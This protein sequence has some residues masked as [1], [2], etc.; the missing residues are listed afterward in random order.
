MSVHYYFTVFPMEAMIASE[1]EPE[2]FGSYM[3]IGQKKMGSNEQIIFVEL[4]REFGDYFDWEYAK[5]KCIPHHDGR[6][7]HSVY[8]SVYRVLENIPPD[9]LGDLYLTTKDGRSLKLEKEDYA[10]PEKWQGYGL[11]KELCP[12]TPLVVSINNPEKFAEYIMSP[13]NKVTVPALVFADLKVIGPDDY[14][15]SGNLGDEYDNNLVHMKECIE[16]LQEGKG[17]IT[18]IVDRSYMGR[19]SY[20]AIETG[21][22]IAV[23]GGI[24]L[25]RMP[26]REDLK[27]NS[28]DWAKSAQIY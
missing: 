2:K 17:K 6:V 24:V 9:A 22:Y 10:H 4:T 12:V 18:K 14:H 23:R 27:K 8:L 19:F 11:Y 7:K 21:I 16:S 5:K 15:N 28:Y 25:Y 13:L 26:S 3:A 1:L 20:Q